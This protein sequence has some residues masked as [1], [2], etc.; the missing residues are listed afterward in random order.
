[1]RRRRRTYWSSKGAGAQNGREEAVMKKSPREN[2]VGAPALAAVS[3]AWAFL[4]LDSAPPPGL[5]WVVFACASA[6]WMAWESNRRG[7]RM[8]MAT[9]GGRS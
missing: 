4:F 8:A 1:M 9:T 3:V 7:L 5:G 2:A 6:L